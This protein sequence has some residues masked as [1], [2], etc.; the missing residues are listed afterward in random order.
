M[1]PSSVNRQP[2][3]PG[4]IDP[5]SEAGRIL[6]TLD[7]TGNP[8]GAPDAWPQSLRTALSICLSSRF[9]ILIWWGPELVMLYN[10]AYSQ[11]VADKHPRALGQ[12]GRECFPEIWDIIGPRLQGVLDRGEA[13]WSSDELLLLVR[14][15]FPEECYFT[16]SY[17][18]IR[19][20]SGGVGGIFT[21]VS[22]TTAR[23]LG[24]RRLAV[25]G[26]IAGDTADART[27]AEASELAIAALASDPKD[28]PFA[29]FYRFE[30]GGQLR[31]SASTPG[32][33]T[34]AP[35]LLPVP[36]PGKVDDPL[37]RLGR[38]A[39]RL[40]AGRVELDGAP[41]TILDAW[42]EPV[43]HAMILPVRES[44]QAVPHG[45]AIFGVSP[46]LELDDGYRRFFELVAGQIAT[47][48]SGALA[49]ERERVRA[50]A[51]AELDRVKTSFFSNVS[52][53]FRT[54][55]TLL[56]GPLDQLV[57][58]G[59]G[60][61][62][63]ERAQ[64]EIARRNAER[65]LK[66]VNDLLDFSRL[67]A[68]RLEASLQPTDLAGRT[69]EA[70]AAFRSAVESAGMSLVVDC[71]PLSGPVDVDPELWERVVLNLVSNAFKFTFE[72]GIEVR[73]REAGGRV[74]LE[75]ADTGIG[76]EPGELGRVFERFHRIR[77]GRARTHEGAGI[78]LALVREIA[79]LHDGT[80]T[81]TSEP[82]HGSTFAVEIPLRASVTQAAAPGPAQ[83]TRTV[84]DRAGRRAAAYA[85]ESARWLP[86]PE[87]EGGMG[88]PG[89]EDSDRDRRIDHDAAADAETLAGETDVE[90]GV[91]VRTGRV[92]LVD[93]NADMR[94]YVARLLR[95]RW[96]VDVA[97]DGTHAL[98]LARSRPPDLVVTDVMMPGLDGVELLRA[99]R[100]DRRTRLVPIILLSARAGEVPRVEGIEAGADDY[101]VKPFTAR[102]L[103][104]RVGTHMAL[105][106]ARREALELREA[107]VGLVS[108]ELRTPVTTIYGLTQL[109]SR[110]GIPAEQREELMADVASEA[111]RMRLL[112][113]DLLALA[114]VDGGELELPDEPVMLGHLIRRT[115]SLEAERWPRHTFECRAPA[116]FPPVGGD[117]V[118]LEQVIRNLLT[119]AAKYSPE[120]SRIDVVA[121]STSTEARVRILDQGIGIREGDGDRLFQMFYRSPETAGQV[122]GAGIGLYVCR[123]LVQTMG[124][125]VWALPRE[126]GGSEFGF[127]VPVY[128]ADSRR[129]EDAPDGTDARTPSVGRESTPVSAGLRAMQESVAVRLGP[130]E[131]ER[132]STRAASHVPAGD[133]TGAGEFHP[134]GDV[135]SPGNAAGAFSTVDPAG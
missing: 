89:R 128:A 56:L 51:L 75:V 115:L 133:G 24:E 98:E 93:D 127:S 46:R 69:A 105:A 135:A 107:F 55:L 21:A 85:E 62:G 64:I 119:N 25:L 33:A 8:I 22:E 72:G 30:E 130:A 59:S 78:G 32:A 12:R 35:D 42:G 63:A 108:H 20:E 118:Y 37:G 110:P 91:A 27:S 19:D 97:R 131:P 61:G 70:A 39:R 121:E 45:V 49:H 102:E 79:A 50:E 57:A 74:R 7:W 80:A 1:I 26:R 96:T 87:P 10:D 15:G 71:P 92:L 101:L 83:R 67:E 16:F 23:I 103:V 68:G 11:I 84:G 123:R 47:A 53:E 99:L 4:L 90:G 111:E 36:V 38:L 18:P 17:S 86:A 3:R 88:R 44:G 132:H 41:F 31:R 117:A 34:A 95:T 65:L 13:T 104:A 126:G 122:G 73:L 29:W 28:I 124:G 134:A 66:L 52:H 94:D 114:R 77:D 60:I 14:K 120:G 125:R 129:G 100:A 54:P 6:A 106:R 58:A 40:E 82:G 81:V 112:V 48:L 5:G 9:P 113:E 43:R 2:A 109:W 76:I 116:N